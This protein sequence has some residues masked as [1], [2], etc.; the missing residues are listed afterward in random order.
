MIIKV[1]FLLL[2][3]IHNQTYEDSADTRKNIKINTELMNSV[4][5]LA[6]ADDMEDTDHSVVHRNFHLALTE[7]DATVNNIL[8]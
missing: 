2:R 6:L 8:K 7:K 4:Q 1:V 3:S 5:T